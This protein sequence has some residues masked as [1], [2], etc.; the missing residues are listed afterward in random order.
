MKK[1]FY[2][3]ILAVAVGILSNFQYTPHEYGTKLQSNQI[4]VFYSH[5]YN[6]GLNGWENFLGLQHSFDLDK[7]RKV[8][9][10]L[11]REGVISPSQFV[12]PRKV[13]EEDL[14][15]VHTSEYLKSL[16]DSSEVAKIGILEFSC[17][18]H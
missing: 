1:V 3:G 8:Y 16:Q 13:S 17:N 14:M 6:M 4:P 11:T 7:Y 5:S 10:R 2:F 18:F 12:V 9:D 15:M